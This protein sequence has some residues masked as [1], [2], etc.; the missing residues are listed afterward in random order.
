MG[1]IRKKLGEYNKTTVAIYVDDYKWLVQRGASES[2]SLADIFKRIRGE[3]ERHEVSAVPVVL[4]VQT[5]VSTLL[6][7]PVR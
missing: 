2:E 4:P 3:L 7:K 6:P 1:R 5:P